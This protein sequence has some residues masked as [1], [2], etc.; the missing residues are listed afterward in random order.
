MF[1]LLPCSFCYRRFAD[2]KA[3]LLELAPREV[4]RRARALL[5]DAR[6]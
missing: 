6:S 5:S 3:C 1:R 4:A 2:T